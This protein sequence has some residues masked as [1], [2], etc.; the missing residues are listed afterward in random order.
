MQENP[1]SLCAH[2]PAWAVRAAHHVDGLRRALEGLPGAARASYDH[3]GSTAVPALAAKPWIDLQVSMLPLPSHQELAPR[4]APLGFAQ[5]PGS[6]PDSPGVDRD[7][8]RG[9]EPVPTEV[10]MKRLYVQPEES[11]ILHVRRSDSPWA[12]YTVWF[13][14]WLRHHPA[15]RARYEDT[16]RRLS[17]ENAGKPDYDD[18]T[19]AKTAFF[20][21]VQESFTSWARGFSPR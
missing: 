1:A 6:R 18:Y 13:R 15:E 16:K 19:R 7:V 5:A 20:D 14:D 9:G 8:P 12:R 11:V 10:W 17:E 21:E 4:L 2:D 3:I